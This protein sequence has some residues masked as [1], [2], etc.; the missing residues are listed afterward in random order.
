MNNRLLVFAA[1]VL[2]LSSSPLSASRHVPTIDEL[3]TLRQI[4]GTQI[5]PDGKL[6]AYT[7]GYGDFKQDAFITQIWIAEVASGRTFQLTRGAKSSTNPRW[8]P[9]GRWLTFLS[10]R[11]DD[12]NQIFAIDPSGGES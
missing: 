7:V 2:A 8:S 9:D 4:G 5:S 6:I 10:N 11:A 1:L 3:L 12:K